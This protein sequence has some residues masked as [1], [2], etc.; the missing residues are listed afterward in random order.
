MQ[1]VMRTG[2]LV[3]V[4]TLC[5]VLSRETKAAGYNGPDW[6][7][8]CDHG[9]SDQDLFISAAFTVGMSDFAAHEDHTTWNSWLESWKDRAVEFC[10]QELK[11]GRKGFSAPYGRPD[12][13][14]LPNAYEI[15][16]SGFWP[17]FSSGHSA[18]LA[19][20]KSPGKGWDI[21]E[22]RVAKPV[23]EWREF[24]TRKQEIAQ[25]QRVVAQSK[26][27]TRT[28]FAQA[29][30]VTRFISEEELVS[31]PF[32]VKGQTVGFRSRFVR[33]IS[34]N[35]AIFSINGSGILTSGVPPT[36]FRGGED[37]VVAMRVLGIKDG[38]PYG[39]YMGVF[40]CTKM[41]PGGCTEFFD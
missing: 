25:Q 28:A 32:V 18:L 8:H 37:V 5:L 7:I 36:R 2:S 40:Q 11:G 21:T 31:N 14:Q 24:T 12:T 35:E 34:E 23:A 19:G 41:P 3:A 33:M 38:R 1:G 13:R 6:W 17:G 4:A 20:K 30:S 9:F 27:A 29:N 26:S 15:R 16:L 39:E 10:R 22:K